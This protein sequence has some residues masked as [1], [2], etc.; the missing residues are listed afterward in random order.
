[1]TCRTLLPLSPAACGAAPRAPAV[2]RQR[3][4]IAAGAGRAVGANHVIVGFRCAA[5]AAKR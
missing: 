1:M 2:D 5:D 4:A 3:I